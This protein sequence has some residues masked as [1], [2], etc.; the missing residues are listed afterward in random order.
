MSNESVIDEIKFNVAKHISITIKRT[1]EHI[2]LDIDNIS[3]TMSNN[4]VRTTKPV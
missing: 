3:E 1:L 4:E 2:K